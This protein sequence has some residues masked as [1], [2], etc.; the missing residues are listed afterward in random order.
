M[1][2]NIKS[3][4]TTSKLITPKQGEVWYFDPDPVVGTELGKKVRP[5]LI[6][7]C[8]DMNYGTSGLVIVIPMT[9]K[10]KGIDSHVRI[11]PPN[12]GLSKTSFLLCEQIRA[13]SKDRLGDKIGTLDTKLYEVLEWVNDLLRIENRVSVR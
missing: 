1:K 8:D 10:N 12:G 2:T 7:S 11:D 4:Q 5:A 3:K 6:I 13:I 9:S